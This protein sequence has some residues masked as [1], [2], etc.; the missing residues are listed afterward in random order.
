VLYLVL[1]SKAGC[2]IPLHAAESFRSLNVMLYV[3]GMPGYM[4]F[5]LWEVNE[6]S[7]ITHCASKE[8]AMLARM[9]MIIQVSLFAVIRMLATGQS[10][11]L[12]WL[13]ELVQ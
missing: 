5:S 2:T 7:Y 13:L 10:R 1:I 3:L 12:F 4:D 9:T 8:E 11:Y 6:V